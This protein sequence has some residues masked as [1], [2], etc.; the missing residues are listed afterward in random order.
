MFSVWMGSTACAGPN[1]A[2]SASAIPEV[3]KVP[4]RFMFCLPLTPERPFV[5]KIGGIVRTVDVGVAV[6]AAARERVGA[7]AGAGKVGDVAA[8]ASRLV[9]LLAQHRR[10]HLEQVRRG[11]AVRV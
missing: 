5:G 1:A 6:Q 7:G 11:G 4:A 10:A 2:A 9:A 3:L 8:V